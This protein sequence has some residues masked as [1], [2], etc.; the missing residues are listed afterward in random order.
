MEEKKKYSH[1]EV[2]IETIKPYDILT[3]SIVD[4]DDPIKTEEDPAF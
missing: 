3:S 1:P 4:D 2:E